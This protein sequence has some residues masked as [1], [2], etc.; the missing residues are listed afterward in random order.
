VFGKKVPRGEESWKRKENSVVKKG[1]KE[2]RKGKAKYGERPKLEAASKL[3]HFA[4]V[5]WPIWKTEKCV[6]TVVTQKKKR[7]KLPTAQSPDKK[8]RVANNKGE[9]PK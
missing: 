3:T 6:L 1:E 9:E 2:T 7:I 4:L 5:E 8:T